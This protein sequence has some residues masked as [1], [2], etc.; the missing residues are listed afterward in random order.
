MERIMKKNILLA[1]VFIFAIFISYVDAERYTSNTKKIKCEDCRSVNRVLDDFH[2]AA[3]HADEIRYFGHLA[4][5]AVFLG[6]DANERWTKD[7][8]RK[9]ARPHFSK[10]RG[11][12]YTPRDRHVMFSKDCN[13]AW[14]D[15][16]LYNKKYGELR[17]SGVLR[18]KKG[19][20][21][22]VFYNMVFT[23]PNKVARRVVEVIKKDTSEPDKK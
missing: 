14:F 11:W 12:S 18:K 1:F 6:T 22:I 16:R 21:K 17:G 19:V 20:W 4:E 5:D 15:E 3:A 9:Y 7:E 13:I 8:F 10:G 2:D 23:I